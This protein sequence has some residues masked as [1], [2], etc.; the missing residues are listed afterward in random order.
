[1]T[2]WESPSPKVDDSLH[3]ECA[4]IQAIF[5][6]MRLEQMFSAKVE[7]DTEALNQRKMHKPSGHSCCCCVVD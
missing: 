1:M 6:R 7:Q 5:V 4:P 3:N 2:S